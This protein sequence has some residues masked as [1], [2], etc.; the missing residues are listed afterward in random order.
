MTSC[1]VPILAKDSAVAP[2]DAS[3]QPRGR[4]EDSNNPANAIGEVTLGSAAAI[5]VEIVGH[6]RV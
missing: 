4:G 5:R 3:R 1:I 2:A 6:L